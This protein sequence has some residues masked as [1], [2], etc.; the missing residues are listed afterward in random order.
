[1]PTITH[2]LPAPM[3]SNPLPLRLSIV[4]TTASLLAACAS[5]TSSLPDRPGVYVYPGTP[6]ATGPGGGATPSGV[7][8]PPS[9]TPLATEQRFLED[10]FRGT[11]V[12][13]AAQPPMTLQLDVPLANSFDAGKADVK[14]ALNAVLERVAESLRRQTA[15]RLA[16]STPADASGSIALGQA[17]AQKVRDVLITKGIAATRVT[18]SD[19]PRMGGPVQLRLS[20]PTSVPLVRRPANG[21][22]AAGVAATAVLGGVKP[23]STARPGWTEKKP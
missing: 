1:M 18:L 12:V 11:P 3:P 4:V 13:I 10:W 22:P 5:T 21:A 17:R 8:M 7:P 9:A 6:G 20:L 15:G 2:T 16:V 23:V 19:M 14:P